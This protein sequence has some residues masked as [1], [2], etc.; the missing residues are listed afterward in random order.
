MIRLKTA[1]LIATSLALGAISANAPSP[2]VE[3]MYQFGINIGL[4]FQLQ[5]DYLDVFANSNEFGK[6]IGGDILANKKT[7]LMISA[8][9]SKDTKQV[10]ELHAWIKRKEYKPEDKIKAVTE[11]YQNLKVDKQ[12]RLIADDYFNKGLKFLEDV[13]LAKA[14]KTELKHYVLKLMKRDR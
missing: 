1:V 11:I 2:E 5:D 8:L 3:K 14:R 6:S 7:F 10:N 12:L 4:A 13:N 9:N